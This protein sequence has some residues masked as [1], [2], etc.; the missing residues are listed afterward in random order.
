MTSYIVVSLASG[1]LF[2]I[3][4]GLINGNPLAARLFEV[5]RPIARRSL[6]IVA[7]VVID[8]AY[9]FIL[10]GLFLLI[11]ASLP[12]S[13]GIVKGVSFGIIVWLLR[14]AMGAASQWMM[15]AV[16]ANTL[17]YMLFTGL[18]EMLALGVLYGLTLQPIG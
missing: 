9:G 1:V 2:G 11:F 17:L 6:N 18:A 10:A 3:L 7:G 15:F 12:G 4:D 13:P 5:Y 8:L 14:V 16:P